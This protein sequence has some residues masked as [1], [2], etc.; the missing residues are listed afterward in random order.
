M[1][2][3]LLTLMRA[4]ALPTVKFLSLIRVTSIILLFVTALSFN[5]AYIQAIGY[6][7]GIYSGLFQVASVSEKINA[8]I[9]PMYLPLSCLLLIG[10]IGWLCN[11]Y[12]LQVKINNT[13]TLVTLQ[14]YRDLGYQI[15]SPMLFPYVTTLPNAFLPPISI[16]THGKGQSKAYR[17]SLKSQGLF[18]QYDQWQRLYLAV[19]ERALLARQIK[20]MPNAQ[21]TSPFKQALGAVRGIASKAYFKAIHEWDDG[22][23][24]DNVNIIAKRFLASDQL[25]TAAVI[26]EVLKLEGVYTVT[27]DILEVFKL[28]KPLRCVLPLRRSTSADLFKL[29]REQAETVHG[30]GVYVWTLKSDPQ[31]QYV[32]SSIGI[33]SR[34]KDHYSEKGR[35]SLQTAQKLY[36]R[37][38]FYLDVYLLPKTD[39]LSMSKERVL[40]FEQYMIFLLDPM[41]NKNK[42]ANSNGVTSPEEL[43]A[44][45]QLLGKPV[46]V[47]Y[48]GKHIHTY[49]SQR[50]LSL[51]LGR[52]I[53]YIAMS[54]LNED[55]SSIYRGQLGFSLKLDPNIPQELLSS[56][57]VVKLYHSLTESGT[58]NSP[59][60]ARRGKAVL[61]TNVLTGEVIEFP[62]MT[63]FIPYIKEKYG[64]KV[65]VLSVTNASKSGRVLAGYTLRRVGGSPKE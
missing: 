13:N 56:E 7:K 44:R 22:R 15:T 59:K 35:T 23:E 42:V 32:G 61:A 57:E 18:T 14:H 12:V 60:K 48:N 24:T 11:S 65:S 49:L 38:E 8:L 31:V 39:A 33:M 54:L 40:A 51:L 64:V 27:D 9:Y 53:T 19:Q 47:T 50:Q 46:Y 34:I 25:P 26:N 17:Q 30:V 29:V 52:S 37:D 43:L 45:R 1:T 4:V 41:I 10:A 3:L 36:G 58:R 16:L 62:F 55:E 63:A 6:D 21:Y 28:I 5:A 2:N 20:I